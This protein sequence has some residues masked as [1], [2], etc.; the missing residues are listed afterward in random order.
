MRSVNLTNQIDRRVETTLGPSPA[1]TMN[2]NRNLTTAQ[3]GLNSPDPTTEDP[4]ENIMA[5][6]R[7]SMGVPTPVGGEHSP[8]RPQPHPQ[9]YLQPVLRPYRESRFQEEVP[10]DAPQQ[11]SHR[12]SLNTAPSQ[13]DHRRTR[14]RWNDREQCLSL[15]T[16]NGVL[17]HNSRDTMMVDIVEDTIQTA[18][19]VPA[20]TAQS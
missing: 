18:L 14:F 12:R 20:T 17:N 3:R 6:S 13:A 2:D 9:P 4:T 8:A 11:G 10:E 15:I 7:A 5:G 19:E 1:P 16:E